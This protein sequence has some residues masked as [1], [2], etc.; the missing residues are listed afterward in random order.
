M[1]FHRVPMLSVGAAC[2]FHAA[3][4]SAQPPALPPGLQPVS[5]GS[6]T[7]TP[8]A[9]ACPGFSWAA[10]PGAVGYEL[11]VHAVEATAQLGPA[12]VLRAVVPGAATSWTPSLSD[13]LEPGA[14][15]M[16]FVREVGQAG[17]PVG[18]W[19]D[20]MAFTVAGSAPADTG[21]PKG[22]TKEAAAVSDNGNGSG[23]PAP[24]PTNR[25]ILTKLTE[26]LAIL[27]EPEPAFSF[28]LCTEP[29][30]QG[31]V[32]AGSQL[33]LD[34]TIEGRVGAE[35]YGNGAMVRLKG[36]PASRL[37]AK[38]KGGWDILK[39]GACW[40]IGA[41]VRNRRAAAA[42]GM[43]AAPFRSAAAVDADLADV[44]AG[45]DTDDLRQQLQGLADKLQLDP[46][47]SIAALQGLGDMTF[48]G[49]VFAG[50]GQQGIFRQLAQNIP[51][52]VNVRTVLEDPSSLLDQFQQ[53]RSQGLCNV[54]L[55]PALSGPVGQI[56]QLIANE[57]F[58]KL[59]NRV[60]GA[61]TTINGVVSRIESALP[62]SSD[63]KFF[64][65]N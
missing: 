56:C 46:A 20:G 57:P 16:W 23:P 19:S 13:C 7:R 62:T 32:E 37:D 39:F 59:L 36:A 40:D 4:V 42:A 1:S 33:T 12:P 9:A 25:E 27:R 22:S 51:L 10:K 47:R 17:E 24:P 50:L 15:Y 55:P 53:L 44:V 2:L 29:A 34:G 11:A 31:E 64:C 35:G 3:V 14:S 52:P 21:G 49:G 48:D 38:L 45:L 58:G 8:P 60:D 54:S 26:V 18:G 65:K 43:P 30:F 61:V 28:V 5:P 6:F 63:C 41:T